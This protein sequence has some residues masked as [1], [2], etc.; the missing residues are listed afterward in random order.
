MKNIKIDNSWYT[1]DGGT[2]RT[3]AGGVIARV[4]GDEIYI[5]LVGELGL[6][7]LVLPKGGVEANETLEEAARREIKEEAGLTS[8]AFVAGLGT[9]ERYDL[10]KERW[11][12]TH[13][14]LCTTEQDAGIPTDSENHFGLAWANL[15]DLPEMFWPEQRELIESNR[16]FILRKLLK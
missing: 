8:I 6:S 1:R 7:A 13:Y 10:Y 14:F 5:A 12:T 3:S 2:D 15:N 16:D 11:I 9:R 4:V